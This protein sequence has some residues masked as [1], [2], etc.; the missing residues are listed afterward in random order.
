[1]A[2]LVNLR[3]VRREKAR[4]VAESTAA[5][6]RLQHGRS[7]AERALAERQRTKADRDLAAHELKKDE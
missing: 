6:N 1:M 3:R 4:Q 2:E 7:K 5:A